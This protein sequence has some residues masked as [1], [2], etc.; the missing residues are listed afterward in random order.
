MRRRSR[1]D[2]ARGTASPA[3][4][5]ALISVNDRALSLPYS[6]TMHTKASTINAASKSLPVRA[7][8]HTRYFSSDHATLMT[9]NTLIVPAKPH[10]RLA[11]SAPHKA[12]ISSW[13]PITDSSITSA[14]VAQSGAQTNTNSSSGTP[15]TATKILCFIVHP[16]LL[17][18]A[19]PAVALLIVDDRRIQ[20]ALI[21]IGP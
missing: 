4:K 3:A 14:I 7:R 11:F 13:A 12:C 19:E 15:T 17:H 2:S 20:R 8:P 10:Q 16:S 5:T 1:Q 6:T 21:K 18:A 9:A